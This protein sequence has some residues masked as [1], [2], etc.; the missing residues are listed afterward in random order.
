MADVHQA[1]NAS[2]ANTFGMKFQGLPSGVVIIAA[3]QSI[4]AEVEPT[5]R[6]VVGLV[7]FVEAIFGKRLAFAFRTVLHR[8]LFALNLNI[9]L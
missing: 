5:G 4:G 8:C 2:E 9:L 7:A 1:F 6:A 3:M